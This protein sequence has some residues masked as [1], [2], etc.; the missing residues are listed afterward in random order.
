VQLSAGYANDGDDDG[1]EGEDVVHFGLLLLSGFEIA[2]EIGR[3][4]F[5]AYD[6]TGSD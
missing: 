2:F 1:D 3:P 4:H 5:S 6:L